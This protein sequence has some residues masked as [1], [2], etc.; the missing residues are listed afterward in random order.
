MPIVYRGIELTNRYYIDLVVGNIVIV[1]LKAVSA[2]VDIHTR[3]VLN[4][5]Q[6]DWL[7]DRALIN[8][9]V[10]RLTDGVKR[11]INSDATRNS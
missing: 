10:A 4:L 3:Q 11:V 2:L 6:V 8:F 9:N 7:A 1:E 5:S